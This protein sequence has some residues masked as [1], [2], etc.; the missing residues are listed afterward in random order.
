MSGRPRLDAPGSLSHIK[1]L[2]PSDAEGRTIRSYPV[3]LGA[4]PISFP[5]KTGLSGILEA[6][7]IHDEIHFNFTR[8]GNKQTLNDRRNYYVTI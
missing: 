7:G 4:P 8:L 5:K 3:L 2:H 6:H 1:V